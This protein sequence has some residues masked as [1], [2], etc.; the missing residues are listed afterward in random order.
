VTAAP[1]VAEGT[2]RDTRLARA[3]IAHEH[4]TAA[5]LLALL[6]LVYLCSALVEGD[7][8]APTA[9]AYAYAPWG[10][11]PPASLPYLNIDLGDAIGSYYPWSVLAREFVHA[12]TFPAWNPYALGGTPLFANAQIAWLSPFS[13]P[14]WILPLHTGL[15]VAAALK[16]WMAGFGAYLLA[17]ELRLGF[18]P[19]IVAGVS[20][21]LCAFNVVWLSYGP[22]VS[23]AA[24]L[25]WA[26]WLA[27]R[28]VRHGR[29]AD[30]LAL[31]AVLAVALLS[32]HP[33]T[34]LHLL[35]GTAIYLLVRTALVQDVPARERAR[36]VGL[37][38]GAA[39]VAGL[40]AAVVL[41]PAAEV[42]TGTYGV[43][44]RMNGAPEFRS[45]SI[46]LE[47]LRTALF[48][49]WWGRPSEQLEAIG[50]ASYKERT[51]YAGAVTLLLAC[52]ALLA[53][54]G[55]RR[56]A[57]FAL[58][59]A[60]G[61]AISLRAAGIYDL[62]IALPGF[63]R[64]QNGRILLWFLL[65]VS[66]LGGFGLQRL[67]DRRGR[68][69]LGWAVPAAALVAVVLA[70]VPLDVGDAWPE[71]VDYVLHRAGTEAISPISL[72]SVIWFALFAGAL[73]AIL[74]L[75]RRHGHRIA[76]VGGLVALVVALDLLHFADGYQ[77]IGPPEIT[78][79][80]PTEAIAF[81]QEHRDEG[82]I[83]AVAAERA[84]W[85]GLYGL[86]DV[87]GADEPRPTLRHARLLNMVDE[88][89]NPIVLSAI[90]EVGLRVLGM[91]GARYVL[92]PPGTSS[93]GFAGLRPAYE[94]EDA[95]VFANAYAIPRVTTPTR[96]RVAQ[97]EEEEFAAVGDADFAPPRD[98]L[99]RAHE[100]GGD[101]LS[102]EGGGTARVV[103]ESNASVTLR[104]TLPR[105]GLVVLN[106]SWDEGWRVEVDGRP[107]RP[108]QVDVMLR[109]V[110]VPAGR[111]EIVWRYRV[112][113]LRLGA[114]L[115]AAGLLSALAWGALLI[116]RRRA[117]RSRA[118]PAR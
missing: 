15:G 57:P 9:L 116:R 13:L 56:M 75:A 7:L 28:I 71:A 19:G 36:R 53:R 24:M 97:D 26:L 58:L 101:D 86:R 69:G 72:A 27:E 68:L 67:L 10:E 98:A 66:L 41:I 50:P 115:S 107:A 1:L 8:L 11:Y 23:V 5:A 89:D 81:L 42:A 51:Y 113:G 105:R 34:Q 106:D 18:W 79:P 87:R 31:V 94:G 16:L 29:A 32:G 95:A 82:R 60:L 63:D 103:A 78:V 17:R 92:T 77:P 104:A 83:A 47:A 84:D 3:L 37:A 35:A 55:W 85:M 22:F 73:V 108:L 61:L 45:S 46:P 90:S 49:E 96:I 114:I 118:R 93:E 117:A 100:I 91:L 20:F 109:G 112:P 40:I 64:I 33:G 65:A 59:G 6:V 12:G 21:A 52:V 70:S 102:R 38:V 25:P 4:R 48:P 54:N 2:L 88:D 39:G 80:P 30:G 76:L 14:L 74:L 43:E 44:R 99:V 110:V 62:V 111:H